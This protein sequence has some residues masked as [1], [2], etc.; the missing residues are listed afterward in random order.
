MDLLT[1]ILIILLSPVILMA[2]LI[3]TSI[4]VTLI[5]FIFELA[6]DMAQTISDLINE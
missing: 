5:A 4:L 3:S 6:K 2:I 1:V